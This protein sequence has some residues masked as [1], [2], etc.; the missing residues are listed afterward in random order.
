MCSGV[1]SIIHLVPV[2][3][4]VIVGRSDTSAVSSV[5]IGGGAPLALLC[6]PCVLESREHA[7]RLAESITRVASG[8]GI[9]LVFKSSYDK[10]NRTSLTGYR[11]V[12]L[13]LG[14]RILGEVR[15]ELNIPVVT[16]VHGLE[17]ARTAAEVVDIIQIPAFL[18]RQ[19]DL[20]VAAGKTGKPIMVKKGQF[21]H[22]AD[23]EYVVKKV[24]S[25]G[26]EQIL[27]CERGSCF[28]Y[29]ELVVDFRS[30]EI[31]ARSGYPVVF[32]ATHSVQVMGGGGGVSSGN[33]EFVQT[34]ARAAVA[35]GIDALFLEC[36]QA[37][38]EAPSDGPNMVPLDG[39]AALLSD[40][41]RLDDVLR[42][43]QEQTREK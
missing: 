40:L 35:V 24:A 41:K 19:T 13:E 42:K 43:D 32:D 26:N 6:G 15:R 31:M 20:L 28:G 12:G 5:A 16:D 3:R 37:P 22:P 29:R 33:R 8:T 7:L 18:C 11:G 1:L 9:P 25:G 39:L 38:D 30:L 21:M 23:M 14:L 34:L 36:H 2:S 10:A 27:L 17:E 4:R